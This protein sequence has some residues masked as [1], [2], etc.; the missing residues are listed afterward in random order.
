LPGLAVLDTHNAS[1]KFGT[2][3][4]FTMAA[5]EREFAPFPLVDHHL[6]LGINT[7]G[8]EGPGHIV[9]EE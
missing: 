2:F 9:P 6:S 1:L 5:R 3:L 4:I 7:N 8:R